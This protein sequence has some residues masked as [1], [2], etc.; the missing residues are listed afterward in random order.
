MLIRKRVSSSSSV[1]PSFILS[2]SSA[3]IDGSRS[4]AEP[5]KF[6]KVERNSARARSRAVSNIKG[7][8]QARLVKQRTKISIRALPWGWLTPPRAL[9]DVFQ[10]HAGRPTPP[11][12]RPPPFFRAIYSQYVTRTGL[13]KILPFHSS[14]PTAASHPRPLSP[15]PRDLLA[16]LFGRITYCARSILICRGPRSEYRMPV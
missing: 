6:P 4:S 12:A 1:S 11:S 9:A 15:L 16:I 2:V 5:T 14:S 10:S 3:R 7:H 8:L 13:Y